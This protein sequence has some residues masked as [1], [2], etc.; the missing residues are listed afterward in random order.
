[1]D[2]DLVFAFMA[3][4]LEQGVATTLEQG[5]DATSLANA[6]VANPL[7]ATTLRGTAGSR[8]VD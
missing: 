2:P 5:M 8:L 7:E 4:T 1:M 3:I 6:F